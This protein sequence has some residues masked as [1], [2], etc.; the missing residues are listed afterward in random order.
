MLAI[1]GIAMTDR[2]VPLLIPVLAAGYLL[3]VYGLLTLAQR[4]RR[5]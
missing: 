4:R 1:A 3:L 5:V 2:T